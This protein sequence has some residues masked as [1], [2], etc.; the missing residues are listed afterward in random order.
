MKILLVED[1]QGLL[2]VLRQLLVSQQYLVECATDGLMGWELAE[3]FDYDLILLDWMMP[4]LDGISFCQRLR[5]QSCV[6]AAVN[7]VHPNRNT[8]VVC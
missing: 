1:D 4:G 5:A 3:A 6:S 7:S 8:P 2:E